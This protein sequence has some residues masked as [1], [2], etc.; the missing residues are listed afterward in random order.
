[1]SL[2]EKSLMSRPDNPLFMREAEIVRRL[3]LLRYDDANRAPVRGGRKVP[4]IR[5]AKMA[6]LH[7]VTLYRAIFEGRISD[8]TRKALS[9]SLIMLQAQMKT[10]AVSHP[11]DPPQDKIVRSQDWNELSRC[12]S[13]GGWRFSP[14]IMNGT[15]WHFCDG[16]LP[17]EHYPALGARPIG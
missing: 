17:P 9:R 12:R 8:K 11:P 15:K 4:L 7:R 13:C 10:G 3:R 5:V 1:M 2:C 16:C 14:V 6:G